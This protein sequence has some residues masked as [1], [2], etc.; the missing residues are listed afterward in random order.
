MKKRIFFASFTILLLA[1][2]RFAPNAKAGVLDSLFVSKEKQYLNKIDECKKFLEQMTGEDPTAALGLCMDACPKGGSDIVS[3]GNLARCLS[4]C[5][6][7]HG[8][9]VNFDDIWLEVEYEACIEEANEWYES[10]GGK[11]PEGLEI[12]DEDEEE[13]TELTD[14]ELDELFEMELEDEDEEEQLPPDPRQ[15]KILDLNGKPIYDAT[16]KISLKTGDKADG[17]ITNGIIDFDKNAINKII[18]EGKE[19]AKIVISKEDVDRGAMIMANEEQWKKHIIDTFN[20]YATILNYGEYIDI[21]NHFNIDWYADESEFKRHFM[22]AIGKGKKSNYKDT[23]RFSLE[24]IK[25]KGDATDAWHEGVG[26]ALTETVGASNRLKY[27]GGEHEDPWEPLVIKR[28]WYNPMKWF[29]GKYKMPSDEKARGFASSEAWSHFAANKL[30][31]ELTGTPFESSEYTLEN[32]KK[33]IKRK[34][35]IFEKYGIKG[36]S[37]TRVMRAYGAKVENV[38]ATFYNEIYK[39]NTFEEALQDFV[40]VRLAYKNDHKG[41]T[42]N[43]I[44]E[45]IDYKIKTL[46]TERNSFLLKDGEKAA[47]N[48]EINRINEIA[49]QLY[50]FE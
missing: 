22:N 37:R 36:K 5:L 21:E 11:V 2:A 30:M 12:K 31:Q 1:A 35:A 4:R 28:A 48:E 46:E 9:D 50:I 25:M 39:N 45:F 15:M 16:A 27:A 43:N 40:A 7:T 42:F 13:E 49:K 8:M 17:S 3:A 24:L 20:K 6:E 18:V 33:E 41:K 14:E 19:E 10:V 38:V 26:H 47:I 34:E 29:A 44:N 23:I 32:A